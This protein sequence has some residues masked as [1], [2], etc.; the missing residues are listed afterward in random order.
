MSR[1]SFETG[2]LAVGECVEMSR[3]ERD[4]CNLL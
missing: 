1:Q 2:T 3:L 4:M